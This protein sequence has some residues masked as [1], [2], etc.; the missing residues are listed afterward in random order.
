MTTQDEPSTAA[1]GEEYVYAQALLILSR[2]LYPRKLEVI[3]EYI[4]NA[5]DAIDAFIAISD[6]IDDYTEPQIKIS[7]QGRS[8]MIFDTGIGMDAEEVAKMR[9]V[10]YS[11][12]KAGEEAGYKGIGRLAGIA[13][14]HAPG[15]GQSLA[16]FH[17]NLR[18]TRLTEGTLYFNVH[19]VSLLNAVERWILFGVADYRRALDMFIPSNAPWAHVTLYYSSFFAANAILGMFGA[20][21]HFDR[22]V[23]VDSGTANSQVL[24]ITKR[25]QSPSGYRGS[26]R[27]FWDLFYEGCNTISPWVPNELQSITAPVNNDRIWQITARNEVNYD[28]FNAFDGATILENSFNPKRLRSLRVH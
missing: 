24:R 21:V 3:R 9:R 7:I 19:R 18:T 23:D 25:V 17:N 12:K 5:S 6:Q 20:W 28:M 27:V 4:Q 11:E 10:A 2:D 15:V 14:A 13:V 26:H 22:L 1:A 8:L 16:A